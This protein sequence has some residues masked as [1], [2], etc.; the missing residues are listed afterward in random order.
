LLLL[1]LLLT[2]PAATAA[3]SAQT[4]AVDDGKILKLG[5]ELHEA[6]T[7]LATAVRQAIQTAVEKRKLD[8]Q[9][10]TDTFPRLGVFI[11]KQHR[12]KKVEKRLQAKQSSQRD[13]RGEM[14]ETDQGLL[15]QQ[16]AQ[17]LAF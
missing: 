6:E 1:V 16:G 4:L 14:E 8:P 15:C 17:T 11:E 3:S 12:R 10:T 7:E 5:Y 9:R 13:Q 2:C